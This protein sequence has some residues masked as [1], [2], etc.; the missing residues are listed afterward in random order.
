MRSLKDASEALDM[1]QISFSSSLTT[2][3]LES[4]P[5]SAGLIG[6]D[7]KLVSGGPNNTGC[8]ETCATVLIISVKHSLDQAVLKKRKQTSSLT[9]LFISYAHYIEQ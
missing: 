9:L 5:P 1:Q 7:P 4:V 2:T 8:L 3:K 6:P